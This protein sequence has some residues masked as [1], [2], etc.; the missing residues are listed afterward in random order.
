MFN[1]SAIHLIHDPQGKLARAVVTA[2]Q[3]MIISAHMS[4]VCPP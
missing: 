4:Y 2:V 3:N 1:F